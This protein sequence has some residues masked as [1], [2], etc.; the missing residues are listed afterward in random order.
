MNFSGTKPNGSGLCPLRIVMYLDYFGLQRHPFRI[1]PDPSLFCP[2]GGRGEILQA[3]IY[4]ITVGEGIVKVVGEV[5][6]GKTMLCRILEERL[7]KSVEVV[8]LSNP[9]LSPADILHA[10]AF[11][12]KLPVTISAERL[13][14]MQQLHTYLLDQHCAQRNVVV[15][16]EEAQSMPMDTLEEIRLLSNLETHRHKLLQIVLFGQPELD[17]NLRRREIRQLR[18]RITHSFSLEALKTREVAEYLRFRLQAAGCSK[19]EIFTPQ[20]ERLIARASTGLVRRINILADKALLAAYIESGG[21]V[22]AGLLEAKVRPRHVRAAIRDSEFASPLLP[23][24]PRLGGAVSGLA[25]LIALLVVWYRLDQ[26]AP[27]NILSSERE[28]AV[29]VQR[30]SPGALIQHGVPTPPIHTGELQIHSGKLADLQAGQEFVPPGGSD[31]QPTTVVFVETTVPPVTAAQ[32]VLTNQQ[33]GVVELRRQA[34]ARWLT[35]VRPQ[36]YTVQL[37]TAGSDHPASVERF[38]APLTASEIEEDIFI[39]S[40]R[41]GEEVLLV[42]VYG[43]FASVTAARQAIAELPEGLRRH[44]PFVRSIDKLLLTLHPET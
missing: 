2:T 11:E 37:L 7:P 14:V 44:Q 30:P 19:S 28:A 29:E 25:L 27:L 39:C 3:L 1:T 17:K 24:L 22:G 18:E 16:V 21:K 33:Q 9:R 38:L 35:E 43:E 40:V 20:A 4:A 13:V 15:F 41:Q 31:Q 12:L 26:N 36:H 6:S 5:G 32:P 42:I 8:Y 34:T 23:A 10:I